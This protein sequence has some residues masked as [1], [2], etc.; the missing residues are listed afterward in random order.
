MYYVQPCAY[1]R[2]E[3][4]A[5]GFFGWTCPKNPS[6]ARIESAAKFQVD[7][8]SAPTSRNYLVG[9]FGTGAGLQQKAANVEQAIYLLE[10]KYTKIATGT[11]TAGWAAS[12][13]R[14]CVTN[15]LRLGRD[16]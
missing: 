3:T 10:Q 7:Y 1:L 12:Q 8:A 4:G 15:R 9:L 11:F 2:R 6:A 13:G 14:V 16:I 5:T